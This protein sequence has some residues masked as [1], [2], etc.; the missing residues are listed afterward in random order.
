MSLYQ[1]HVQ[2]LVYACALL[3]P[4]AYLIG[5]VFSLKTHP[6]HVYDEFYA[7]LARDGVS[8]KLSN[9]VITSSA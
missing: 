3:L 9:T 2:P 6:S 4:F 7:Q 8:G 5:L 1:Q